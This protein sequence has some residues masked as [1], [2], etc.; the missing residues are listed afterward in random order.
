MI[1]VVS[2]LYCSSSE[3]VLVVRKRPKVVN[4]G[5]FVVTNCSQRVVFRVDGCGIVGRS[6]EVMLRDG[7]S[8]AF[9]YEGLTQ[10][11]VFS[12]KEP[13]A[14]FSRS[15]AIRVSL[16]QARGAI[17]EVSGSFTDRDCIILDHLG[18]QIAKIGVEDKVD[19]AMRSKDVYHVVIKPGVDQAFVFGVIAVLDYVN[20]EST[21]C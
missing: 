7:N 11:L 9:D 16:E 1:P 3:V 20:Y 5:G 15:N 12:V 4:G 2:K 19:Q 8:Y 18:N 10:K 14:C 6:G 13:N 21:R 17:F